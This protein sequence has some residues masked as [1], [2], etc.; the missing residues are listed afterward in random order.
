MNLSTV[1]E[2]RN[3]IGMNNSISSS[4]IGYATY[5]GNNN[6]LDKVII[7]RF[8]SIGSNIQVINGKH[9]TKCFVSTHP[10]FFS[11]RKQS[12]FTYVDKNLFDEDTKVND[13]FNLVI[14]NDVWIGTNV[15]ILGGVTIKNG[16][17]IGAN[18]LVIEDCKPYF[19]YAGVPAKKI[20]QR[21]TDEQIEI[22]EKI[23]W[24][25]KD[26]QWIQHYSDKFNDI[27]EFIEVLKNV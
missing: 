11:T 13:E 18:S 2:G 21:F 9:P 27:N 15:S 26:K 25:Q 17:I 22:L 19:I 1:F 8:C 16:A 10:A 24:W 5:M 12:G 3:K 20:G 7:G 4:S 23:K 6:N 14:E